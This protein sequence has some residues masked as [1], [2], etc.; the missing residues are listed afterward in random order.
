MLE[1][2]TEYISGHDGVSWQTMDEIAADFRAKNPLI[3]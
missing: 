1:R 3:A 2:L